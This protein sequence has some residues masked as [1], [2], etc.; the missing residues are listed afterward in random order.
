M[1]ELFAD[2]IN[3][4][5]TFVTVNQ[6]GRGLFVPMCSNSKT[7]FVTVNPSLVSETNKSPFYSKTTF[8]TVNLPPL[9]YK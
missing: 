1:T 5:T 4:K 8:V 2:E 6:G 9:C 3:S 7:T